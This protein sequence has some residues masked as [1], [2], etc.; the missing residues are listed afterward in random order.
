MLELFVEVPLILHLP[1]TTTSGC[2]ASRRVA[3]PRTGRVTSCSQVARA[4]ARV[5]D[6]EGG[7]SV[8]RRKPSGGGWIRHV[9]P[10]AGLA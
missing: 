4:L 6:P 8:R 5:H 7:T 10:S 2:S 3:L 1:D 9:A